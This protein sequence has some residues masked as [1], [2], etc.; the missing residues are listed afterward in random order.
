MPDGRLKTALLLA[1]HPEHEGA[2]R[3]LDRRRGSVQ[4]LHAF[5]ARMAGKVSSSF[6][7]TLALDLGGI[8]MGNAGACRMC[9]RPTHVRSCD[10]ATTAV[11]ARATRES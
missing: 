2:K 1:V 11:V 3:K 6:D 8:E 5:N 7:V 9:E 4:D 10:V